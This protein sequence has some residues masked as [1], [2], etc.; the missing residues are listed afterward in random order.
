M[1]QGI[2]PKIDVKVV[3]R[4]AGIKWWTA[5]LVGESFSSHLFMPR[6]PDDLNAKPGFCAF[7]RPLGL[8][9]RCAPAFFPKKL[10]TRQ[11]PFSST[12]LVKV[13]LRYTVHEKGA[14]I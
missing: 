11:T 4:V 7:D 10:E 6:S 2:F 1:G 5:Q 12:E 8:T 3:G 14:P 9:N 13:P